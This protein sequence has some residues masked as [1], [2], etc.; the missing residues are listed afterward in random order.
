MSGN[1]DRATT[2]RTTFNGI[3]EN[4]ELSEPLKQASLEG[5]LGDWTEAL[6]RV[7]V[8]ACEELGWECAAKGHKMRSLPEKRSEYLGQDVMAFDRVD[9]VWRF[10]V[11]TF[12][13]ENSQKDDRIA[14]SLWKVL[15]L[16]ADLRVVFCYRM[17][18]EAGAPLVRKFAE[19][20]VRPMEVL[21]RTHLEGECLVVVGNR[22]ESETFPYGFFKWWKLDKQTGNFQSI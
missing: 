12:E 22:G 13:L 17:D 16:R 18:P 11:A 3:L 7:V 4:R 1:I 10:P 5:R 8:A 20:L 15:C 21:K 9:K 6:T 14:Y 19:E 2:W